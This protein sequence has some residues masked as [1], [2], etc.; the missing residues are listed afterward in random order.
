MT[1]KRQD[2]HSTIAM[3][4]S[5]TCDCC[6]KEYPD[7]MDRQEFVNL[8]F[9]GGYGSVFGDMNRVQLDLCQTCFK[10]KL[11]EYIRVTTGEGGD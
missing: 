1:I 5:V 3:I 7:K 4:V 11:G 10:E 9:I 2:V 8:D 6:G